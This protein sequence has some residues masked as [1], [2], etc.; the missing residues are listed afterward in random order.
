MLSVFSLYDGYVILNYMAYRK[1]IQGYGIIF[2]GGLE[3]A[4]Y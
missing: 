3:H 2:Q 4:I 1:M